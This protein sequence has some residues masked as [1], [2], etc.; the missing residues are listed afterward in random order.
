M[1]TQEIVIALLTAASSLVAGLL[2]AGGDIIFVPLLL[3]GL[4]AIT[5]DGLA[6]HTV[7]ALSLIG[8]LASTGGGGLKHL[9]DGR[10]DRAA[11]RLAWPALAGAALVGG[12]ISRLVP[13]T[14][15]LAAFAVVTTGAAVLLALPATE[16]PASEMRRDDRVALALMAASGLLCGAV[17]V[18]GGFLIIIILLHR[19]GLPA[20]TARSTGLLLTFFTAAPAALG[21]TLSGQMIWGPVPGIVIA[22]V[23]GVWLGAHLSRFVPGRALR[24]ALTL[25]VVVLSARVWMG[26][27]GPAA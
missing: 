21:K 13:S 3:Y 14:A 17:G 18:G 27:L 19:L 7:T 6:V 26:V 2:G 9:R 16:R 25:L 10:I 4:P 8:S 12:A 24:W 11:T 15:L 5:G 1:D 23:G 22:A 20:A